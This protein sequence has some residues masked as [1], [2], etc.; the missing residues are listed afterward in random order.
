MSKTKRTSIDQA[1]CDHAR[2][3][4]AGGAK[5]PEA[6][7]ILG[8]GVSTLYR[9]KAAGYSAEAY[10]QNTVKERTRQRVE[11]VYDPSIME[12]YKKENGTTYS[13]TDGTAEE[14]LPGQIRMELT[15]EKPE[16]NDQTK[17]MRFL[18]SQ[19][20]KVLKKLDAIEGRLWTSG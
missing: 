8:I 14:Q 9:M 4:M 16:M 13:G 3:L 18:A 17:M 1:L 11:M 12:E 15:P 20:E 10:L 7:E 6:A 19:F 5:A 2:L